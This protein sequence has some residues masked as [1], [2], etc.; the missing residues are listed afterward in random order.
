[1]LKFTNGSFCWD[2]H[3]T[4]PTFDFYFKVMIPQ[5]RKERVI[6]ERD[7]MGRIVVSKVPDTAYFTF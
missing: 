1:M 3:F 2:L 7:G 4:V 6:T 5:A